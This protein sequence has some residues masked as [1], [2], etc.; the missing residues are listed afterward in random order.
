M[1]TVENVNTQKVSL[2][3]DEIKIILECILF[4][5]SVD[6]SASWYKEDTDKMLNLAEKLR[7]KY[8]NIPVENI[9][10]SELEQNNEKYMDEQ[11][12]RIV[13]IFPEIQ[14]LEKINL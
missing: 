2:T 11:T 12:K 1:I 14:N 7:M 6:I 4:S 3:D 9:F 5:T 10:V 13:E 8:S